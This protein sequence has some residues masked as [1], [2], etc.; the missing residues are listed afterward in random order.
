MRLNWPVKCS[1]IWTEGEECK[2][3]PDEEDGMNKVEQQK[4]IKM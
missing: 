1:S 4:K 3:F 2:S